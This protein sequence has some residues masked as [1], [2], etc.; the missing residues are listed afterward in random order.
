MMAGFTQ[1]TAQGWT[2][3]SNSLE[4]GE[5]I[6]KIML[7]HN[8]GRNWAFVLIL[9]DNGNVYFSG[10]F[11]DNDH[12]FVLADGNSGTHQTSGFAKL[13]IPG[14]S[15]V[16][17]ITNEYYMIKT[18]EN[19]FYSPTH[20]TNGYEEISLP[21]SETVTK[22]LLIKIFQDLYVSQNQKIYAKGGNFGH[23]EHGQETFNSSFGDWTHISL[24]NRQNFDL[25]SSV[26]YPIDI[27][28]SWGNLYDN[29]FI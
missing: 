16:V 12:Y 21:S 17:D 7:G 29:K 20:S 10:R 22:M 6:I 24:S 11:T 26:E 15:P 4:S 25:D 18:Q 8:D 13:S 14:T 2:E 9:T 19:K 3:I 27:K 5:N 28:T 1:G 23:Y